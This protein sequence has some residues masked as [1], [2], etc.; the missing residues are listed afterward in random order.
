MPDYYDMALSFLTVGPAEFSRFI[1]LLSYLS[2]SRLAIAVVH[3]Y[4]Q[5]RKKR[6]WQRDVFFPLTFA[7]YS[8]NKLA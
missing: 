7:V 3:S 8:A 5:I 2:L 4:H 1:F 6:K